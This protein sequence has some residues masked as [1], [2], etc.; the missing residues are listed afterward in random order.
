TTLSQSQ[1]SVTALANGDFV[2][3]WTSSDRQ[4]GDTSNTAIKARVFDANGVAKSPNP[5]TEDVVTLIDTATL[6]ANDSDVDGD[7]LTV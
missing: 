1:P 6:L 7:A 2:V 3:T 4:Q 5:V